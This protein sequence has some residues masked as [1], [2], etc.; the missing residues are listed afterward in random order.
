MNSEQPGR[1]NRYPRLMLTLTG[2]I[3][4]ILLFL[5]WQAFYLNEQYGVDPAI[6]WL[7]TMLF[8]LLGII[9]W[10]LWAFISARRWKLGLLIFAVP[11]IFF[12]LYYPN[13]G[14]DVAF[15]GFKP[16]FWSDAGDY[17]EPVSASVSAID[18]Q[19]T[20]PSDFPQFM[21]P[22]RN[23]KLAG[24]TLS[25]D[26][27]EPPQE[28]WRI[29]VGEGWSGFAV[30]N[31]FAITQEQR[32]AEECV[33]CYDIKSGELKW[34]N[35]V[36]RRHEDLAA[37]GKAGPRATPTI[38]QGKVY[39][40]SGTGVLD[41]LDGGTGE[42]IWTADVPG[43]VGI[44]QLKSRNSMGLEYTMENSR[45]M[46]GRS[47]SP[48]IVDDLVIVPAGGADGQPDT[49]CTLIAFDKE[50]GQEKWRGGMRMPSYGS[51]SLATLGGKKQILLMAE[52]CAVGHDVETGEELWSFN[53]P[54]NS[55]ADAN[56]SQVTFVNEEQLIL[57]KGYSLGGELVQV[58]QEGD[59]W[60]ATQLHKNPRVMKTKLTNPIV[61][62]GYVYTLSDGYL[63]CTKVDT[64]ERVWK[65]RGRFGNGQIFLVG[66]KLLVHSETG[67]LHLIQATPDGYEELGKFKTISG[68]CWNTIAVSGNLVLLRSE[69]EAA[70]F[71][72]P[73][74]NESE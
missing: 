1:T 23:G 18:L 16:R 17:V 21:G 71:S 11:T 7:L 74:L 32:G 2:I 34:I 61:H 15:R 65:Q 55:N 59:K 56:C 19:T 41:C 39:I 37:M 69:R 51:P 35:R 5:H 53:R 63:E 22:N 33:T 60:V 6:A 4:L 44:E 20:G 28:L 38:D 30:V 47:G 48:L 10:G 31:G 43:L 46:W 52:D 27:S 45:L 9:G 12:I 36:T 29:D 50:T 57:S 68:I 14:G 13:L 26:W 66:N 72:L 24:L 54:G 70:C 58:K 64:F 42:L 40:T 8:G 62:E 25:D 3:S 73:L 67:T 49:T